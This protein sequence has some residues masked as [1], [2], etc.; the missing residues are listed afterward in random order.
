MARRPIH[1]QAHADLLDPPVKMEIMK[2][3][4]YRNLSGSSNVA[5][6]EATEDS[7]HVVFKSGAWRN[8]IY[9]SVRPGKAIVDKMKALA[10][11]GRGLNTFIS[12]S[13]KKNY[14][15]KW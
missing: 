3:M 13:V 11:Q 9:D 14:S 8:Y 10:A 2:M 12:S 15:R 4:P 1:D 6:Y 5:S 7:I